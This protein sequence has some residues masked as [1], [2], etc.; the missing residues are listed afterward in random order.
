MR[1]GR[2]PDLLRRYRAG[3][4]CPRPA[5]RL[6]AIEV[7]EEL[8]EPGDQVGLGEQQ[9]DRHP[10]AELRL[11]FLHALADRAR[12]GDPLRSGAPAMSLMR[13]RDEHAVQRLARAGALEQI[14]ERLPAGAIDRGIGILRR[15][16]AGRCRSARPRR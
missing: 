7:G 10:D 1:K 13:D 14:E 3:T 8:G 9:I 11:Q 2:R 12:M 5:P 6:L 15:V 4:W 16:A